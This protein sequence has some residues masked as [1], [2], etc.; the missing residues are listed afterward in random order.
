MLLYCY[1]KFNVLKIKTAKNDR[2]TMRFL[3]IKK[4]DI[5]AMNI[6]ESNLLLTNIA[7]SLEFCKRNH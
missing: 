5:V 4:I 6:T 2:L 1:N 3:I 7:S